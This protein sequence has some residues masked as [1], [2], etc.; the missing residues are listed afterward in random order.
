MGITVAK[1]YQVNTFSIFALP[2]GFGRQAWVEG[3]AGIDKTGPN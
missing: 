1:R 2:L 3:N